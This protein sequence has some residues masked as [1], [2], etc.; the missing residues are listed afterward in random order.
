[1]SLVDTETISL[2]EL[3]VYRGWDPFFIF[4]VYALKSTKDIDSLEVALGAG[5][6][7]SVCWAQKS[8]LALG[9]YFVIQA[10]PPTRSHQISLAVESRCSVRNL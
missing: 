1:M 2:Q 10:V 4:F 3:L 6:C 8:V 9:E 5:L 7:S